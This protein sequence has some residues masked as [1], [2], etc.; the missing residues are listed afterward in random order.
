[1]IPIYKWQIVL[2]DKPWEKKNTVR[3]W[4][5]GKNEK[6]TK[7]RPRK[8]ERA[9]DRRRPHSPERSPEPGLL[10]IYKP[11]KFNDPLNKK[12]IWTEL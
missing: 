4:D 2:Q 3:E 12:Y 5:V 11:S 1:M 7:E 6:D 9:L 10:L 8:D